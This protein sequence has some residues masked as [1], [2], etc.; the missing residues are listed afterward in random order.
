MVFATHFGSM[1]YIHTLFIQYISC[2]YIC[3]NIPYSHLF[4]LLQYFLNENVSSS[5]LTISKASAA[6]PV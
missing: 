1:L 2:L 5:K 6:M 3:Y 4:L